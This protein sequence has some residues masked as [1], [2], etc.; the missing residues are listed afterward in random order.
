VQDTLHRRGHRDDPLYRIRG[1]LRHGAEHLTDRQIA[2]LDAGL[3]ARDPNW[4]V[5]IAWHAYQSNSNDLDISTPDSTPRS[6]KS[7]GWTP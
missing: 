6:M 2:R 7:R 3:L 5:T 1:L 4:E